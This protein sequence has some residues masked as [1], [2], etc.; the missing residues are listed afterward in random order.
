M[1]TGQLDQ[2]KAAMDDEL[3]RTNSTAEIK[4]TP[5]TGSDPCI[6]PQLA[7]PIPTSSGA[8]LLPGSKT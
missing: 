1:E 4:A 8:V 5:T 2:G 6:L 7:Y 3:E